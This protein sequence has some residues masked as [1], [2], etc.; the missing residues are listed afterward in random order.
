MT[1]VG[2]SYFPTRAD[3]INHYRPYLGDPYYLGGDTT[4]RK[5]KKEK[6]IECDKWV[7]QKIFHGEIHIGKPPLKPGE[8][9]F[10][11]EGRYHI[12]SG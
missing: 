5:T 11:K 3:A 4:P 10:I 8:S 2:T 7:A 6:D 1:I 12:Q 9:L